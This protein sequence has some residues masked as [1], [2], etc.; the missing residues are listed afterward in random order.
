MRLEGKTALV[1]GASSRMGR[2]IALR[3]PARAL[4]R[5]AA[6]SQSG[7]AET[8]S[9]IAAGDCGSALVVPTDLQ[10]RPRSNG[11]PR[12]SLALRALDVLFQQRHRRPTAEL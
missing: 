7:L 4:R 9:E 2:E 5:L 3:S 6:R 11:W 10:R 1:T 12:P 8:A